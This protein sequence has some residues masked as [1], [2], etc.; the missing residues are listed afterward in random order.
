[1]IEWKNI[2]HIQNI[3]TMIL[4]LFLLYSRILVCYHKQNYIKNSHFIPNSR[5]KL[6]IIILLQFHKRVMFLNYRTHPLLIFKSLEAR[7]SFHHIMLDWS[8]KA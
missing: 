2:Y 8:Y 5:I 7:L 4:I 1:M 3:I 6:K